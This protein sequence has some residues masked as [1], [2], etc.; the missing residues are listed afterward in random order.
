MDNE[1]MKNHIAESSSVE[2][3]DNFEMRNIS[4]LGGTN[5]DEHDMRML[6]RNQVLNVRRIG[7][8][9]SIWSTN[10]SSSVTFASSQLLVSPVP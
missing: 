7:E 3:N 4:Q 10:V 5:N 8:F 2:A 9:G 1:I 6:G